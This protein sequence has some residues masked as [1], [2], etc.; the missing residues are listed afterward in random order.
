MWSEFRIHS[1]AFQILKQKDAI[2]DLRL[3][4]KQDAK[5]EDAEEVLVSVKHK[6]SGID[7]H[8]IYRNFSQDPYEAYMSVK[9]GK[10]YN[11]T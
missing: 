10:C 11:I 1:Y 7:V 6:A 3:K 8:F 4:K 5:M 9:I 2:K